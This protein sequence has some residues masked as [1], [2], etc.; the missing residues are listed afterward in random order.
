MQI[1]SDFSEN[2]ENLKKLKMGLNDGILDF[3]GRSPVR[4]FLNLSNKTNP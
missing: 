2:M 3:E 1:F 4:S